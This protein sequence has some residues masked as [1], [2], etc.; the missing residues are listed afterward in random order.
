MAGVNNVIITHTTTFY[1]GNHG[2]LSGVRQVFVHLVVNL[3][4]VRYEA[5]SPTLHYSL[6]DWT[7]FL[8]IRDVKSDILN[9]PHPT[10]L[11]PNSSSSS[12]T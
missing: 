1:L 10:R 12:V 5:P 3:S 9:I 8:K 7:I 6:A 4:Y 2:N 11:R